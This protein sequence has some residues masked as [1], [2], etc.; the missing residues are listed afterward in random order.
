MSLAQFTEKEAIQLTVENIGGIDHTDATFNPGVTIL[1]GRNATNRTSLLQALMAA[2]A[3]N[4]SRSRAILTKGTS[5]S[6]SATALIHG[7]SP[8]RTTL[9]VPQ[10]SALEVSPTLRTPNSPTCSHS[11]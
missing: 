10:R 9:P 2:L 3:A 4:T 5:N 7:R 8:G 6:R 1:A 11:S